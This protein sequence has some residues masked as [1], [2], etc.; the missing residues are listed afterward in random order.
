M[1]VCVLFEMLSPVLPFLR[2]ESSFCS[3]ILLM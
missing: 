3:W 2:L 1:K